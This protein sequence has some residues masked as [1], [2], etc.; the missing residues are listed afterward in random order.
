MAAGGDQDE[1]DGLTDS[2]RMLAYKIGAAGAFLG[3]VVNV[4]ERDWVG[5]A[6]FAALMASFALAALARRA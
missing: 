4:T 2:R 6:L 1:G 5:V 3:V